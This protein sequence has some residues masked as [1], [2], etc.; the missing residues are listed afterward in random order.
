MAEE[1]MQNEVSTNTGTAGGSTVTDY[2]LI[3]LPA[4]K[5]VKL[6]KYFGMRSRDGRKIDSDQVKKYFVKSIHAKIRKYHIQE[7]PQT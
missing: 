7:T 3:V 6:W 4:A 2:K 5:N 1:V